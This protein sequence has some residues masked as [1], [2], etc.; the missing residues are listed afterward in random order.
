MGFY[1][2]GSKK[3]SLLLPTDRT[4]PTKNQEVGCKDAWNLT[5]EGTYFERVHA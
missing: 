2:K 3:Y 4:R 1:V 5:D